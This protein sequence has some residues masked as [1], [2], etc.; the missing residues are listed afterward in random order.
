MRTLFYAAV[1]AVSAAPAFAQEEPSARLDAMTCREFLGLSAQDQMTV[2]LVMRAHVNGDPLPDEP[3][4]VGV[5]AE[6]G[7]SDG[8]GGDSGNP[9]AEGLDTT[10][11]GAGSD[12]AA[13]AG[14]TTAGDETG[15]AESSDPESAA[16]AADADTVSTD[17]AAAAGEG[18]AAADEGNTATSVGDEEVVDGENESGKV[19]PDGTEMSVTDQPG[20]PKLTAMRTSC[21]GGP[22]ALATDA[23]RAAHADYE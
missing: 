9:D 5:E 1:A 17:G 2:M 23:M 16:G 14:A 21:E 3:L 13:A 19:N 18:T 4:P 11:A 20:D 7:G 12:S 15:G 22:D 10:G 8:L 6:V